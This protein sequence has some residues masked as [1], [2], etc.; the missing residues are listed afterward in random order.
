[1]SAGETTKPWYRVFLES[2]VIATCLAGLIT[3][4]VGGYLLE[5]AKDNALAID[6]EREKQSALIA[7]QLQVLEALN[8]MLAEYK[9]AAEFVIFDVVDRNGETLEGQ[10]SILQSIKKFDDASQEFLTRAYQEVFRVRIYF[11]DPAL[12]DRLESHLT[13]LNQPGN[14][15]AID[16]ALSFELAEYKRRMQDVEQAQTSQGVI[17]NIGLQ[18]TDDEAA[19][20]P[21]NHDLLLAMR[22]TRRQLRQEFE[23]VQSI[24]EELADGTVAKQ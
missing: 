22:E 10:D 8:T 9:L 12:C 19:A 11:A 23:A 13:Q 7:N 6:R 3:T 1:M 24:L 17:K 2:S 4:V 16:G 5:L 18:V 15:I 20:T 21:D 14:L